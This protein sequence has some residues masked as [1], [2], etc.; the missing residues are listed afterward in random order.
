MKKNIKKIICVTILWF[1]CLFLAISQYFPS[2]AV[3]HEVFANAEKGYYIVNSVMYDGIYIIKGNRMERT[4]KIIIPRQ[5]GHEAKTFYPND[6]EEYGFPNGIKYVSAQI[7]INEVPKSVFLEEILNIKDSLFFYMYCAEDVDDMFF[8]LEGTKKLRM[9]NSNSPEE[10]WNIFLSMNDCSNI[11]GLETFP[12]KLSRKKIIIFYNA[13]KDCN[14]NLFP[15]FQYGPVV[16]LGFG[17]PKLQETQIYTYRFTPTFSVGGFFQLPFDE[18]AS[19]RTE[20]LYSYLNNGQ[21]NVTPMQR[22]ESG[23]ARY[24]RHS[25][26]APVLIKYTFNFKPWKNVPYMEVGPSFDYSFNGGKFKDNELQVPGIGKIL[27]EEYIVDFQ[28]GV[29]IG[30]GIEHKISYKKSWYLGIRYNWVTGFRQEYVEK[31]KFLGIN[32][33]FNL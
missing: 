3:E 15:K 20:V 21:G 31:L 28:Y 27:N 32:A 5:R 6:I 33:A 14:P 29:A 1:S 25:I 12:K 9:I 17:K 10:V 13:Y 23:S 8:I 11:N 26:Q 19:L 16:N 24:V 30:A 7:F 22:L 4:K 18:C 2:D